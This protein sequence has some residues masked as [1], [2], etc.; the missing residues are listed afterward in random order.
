MKAC[1]PS[2]CSRMKQC[3]N[4]VD[5]IDK[6]KSNIDFVRDYSEYEYVISV[7]SD[8][9]VYCDEKYECGDLSDEYK[10]FAELKH[11]KPNDISEIKDFIYKS[12]KRK[13]GNHVISEKDKE[14]IVIDTKTN[15]HGNS[16]VWISLNYFY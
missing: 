13:Y 8:S 16:D 1:N 9:S 15:F 5:N 6:N 7:S 14:E 4:Y 12:L 3:A 10:M 11:E 2:N